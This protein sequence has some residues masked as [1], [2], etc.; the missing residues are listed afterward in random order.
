MTNSNVTVLPRYLQQKSSKSHLK[1][2]TPCSLVPTL[3]ELSVMASNLICRHT[4][5]AYSQGG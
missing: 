3:K 4:V 2:N 5:K 1:I